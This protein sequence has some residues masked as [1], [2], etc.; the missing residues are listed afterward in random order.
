MKL[1][2]FCPNKSCA[3]HDPEK[4]YNG[5]YYLSSTYTSKAFGKTQCFRCKVCGKYFSEQTF[6]LDYYGKKLVDY[7]QLLDLLKSSSSIRGIS[8][9]MEVSVRT[10]LNR[11]ERLSRQIIAV[12]C[13]LIFNIDIKEDLTA[14]GFET[15]CVSQYFPSNIH[16]LIGKES[17]FIYYLNYAYL[18]RKGRMTEHQKEKREVLE[19]IFKANPKDIKEKFEML[20]ENFKKLIRKSTKG[21][22]S[23]YTDMKSEY[24]TA[25]NTIIGKAKNVEHIRISS[26]KIRN[27]KNPLFSVNYIDREIRKDL[28]EHVR[29]STRFGRNVSDSMNRIVL[30]QYWHNTKKQFRI[31]Q[32]VNVDLT[33]LDIAGYNRTDWQREIMTIY[34]ERRFFSHIDQIDESYKDIWFRKLKTPLKKAKEYLPK[35]A[36]H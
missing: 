18:R 19:K 8:K 30:Y 24:K 14:D 4:D 12:Y 10:V 15:F 11:I 34:E 6:R 7:K 26:K 2:D 29:E 1:P 23:L 36:L 33:H 22:F 16:L 3:Y 9:I 28:A 25:W 21:Y 32:G 27:K 35:F 13:K 20:L 31:N 17:Q 5:Y